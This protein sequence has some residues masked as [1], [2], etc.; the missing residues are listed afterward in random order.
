MTSVDLPRDGC[1]FAT[2]YAAYAIKSVN[3]SKHFV[4]R[5][6]CEH[7]HKRATGHRPEAS[8]PA[9]YTIVHN[10]KNATQCKI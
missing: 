2:I 5:P 3:Y 7:K 9:S 10:N 4:L 1:S 6:I 8:V